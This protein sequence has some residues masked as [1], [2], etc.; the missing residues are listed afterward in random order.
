MEKLKRSDITA[1]LVKSLFNYK[2]GKIYWKNSPNWSI[3]SG[4]MAGT[5]NKNYMRTIIRG[6]PMYNHQIIFLMHHGYL[7]E[8]IDHIDRDRSNDR[9]E[10]LRQVTYSNNAANRDTHITNKSGFKG[11]SFHKQTGK[12][13]AE[14][15]VR[16][17]QMYL[18]LFSDP[19]EASKA[20]NK[21]AIAHF[22]K[23]AKT[24]N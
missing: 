24:N 13:Q 11:V 19:L 7:P 1:D 3:D 6:V 22:G 18:G 14:I 4:A 20:Y 8:C 21:Y 23:Y 17:K 15:Q 16:G 12:Y 10:N 9:L 5:L 2:D